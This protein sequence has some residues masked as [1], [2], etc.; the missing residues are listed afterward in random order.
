[1]KQTLDSTLSIR[2]KFLIFG[3]AFLFLV[4]F[5]ASFFGERGLIEVYQTQK[6]CAAL[7]QEKS[8]LLEKK[9]KLERDIRELR[10]NPSAVEK[11]AREKLWLMDPEE[12]VIIFR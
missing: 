5:I 2:K 11:R 10:S 6:K 1:M 7:A 9:H 3:A 8:H 12:L 4:L